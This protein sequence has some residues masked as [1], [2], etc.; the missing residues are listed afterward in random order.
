MLIEADAK[1]LE[2]VGAAY[3]SQDPVLCQELHDRVDIHSVNQATF[4]LPTRLVA[5]TFKF[6]IIYG[7]TEYA[8]T[9]DSE[10]N[11]I[12]K[13]VN[14][15]K[16]VIDA[17][18]LKYKGLRKWH[19][20]IFQQAMLTGG[21]VSPTGRTYE[22]TPTLGQWPR[23]NILNYPVQGFSADLMAIARV[24]ARKRL[25]GLCL[26]CNTVHDSIVVDTPNKNVYTVCRI[27]E[28]VF[29]DI[30][31]NFRKVFGLDF[32]L[33]MMAEIKFG[34]NWKDMEKYESANHN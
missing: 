15:W 8:F 19:D 6:R 28:E 24:S 5:K 17:Y 30:P 18:Y 22:Y 12:S 27:L 3:L 20:V 31:T 32:N 1:G 23:T 9:M 25:R 11:W 21:Y 34:P 14:F 7:G 26:M 29:Q 4:N 13:D 33:P 2:V 16:G 10:F